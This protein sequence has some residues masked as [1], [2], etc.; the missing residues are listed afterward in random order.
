[1]V[2]KVV[3]TVLQQFFHKLVEHQV[4]VVRKIGVKD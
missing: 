4:P 1:M 3:V 2:N